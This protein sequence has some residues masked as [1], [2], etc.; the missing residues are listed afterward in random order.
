MEYDSVRSQYLNARA[1][2]VLRFRNAEVLN[3]TAR[4]LERIL[5]EMT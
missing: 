5:A 4:V 2:R 3:D 1:F